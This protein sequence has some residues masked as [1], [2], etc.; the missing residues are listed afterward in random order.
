MSDSRSVEQLAALIRIGRA[1]SSTLELNEVLD[2]ILSE[3]LS[4]FDAEA[5]SVMLLRNGALRIRRA[6]GLSD[7]IVASTVVPLGQGIAGNVALT[8][9]MAFLNGKVDSSSEPRFT[10]VVD[11][12][13]AI[14][15]SLC[16]PLRARNGVEGVVMIRR[17]GTV[18]FTQD[19]ADFFC[20]VADQAAM[21][22]EN[23]RLFT[24]EQERARQVRVEQQKLEAIFKSMADGVVVI[25]DSGCVTL[26]NEP[27]VSMLGAGKSWL[28]ENL[29]DAFPVLPLEHI[30]ASLL[31]GDGKYEMDLNIPQAEGCSV[32]RLSA[33]CWQRASG[34]IEGLVFLLHDVTERVQVER[35]KTEF[36][37]A[38][39]HELKT[40]LTTIS[41]FVELLLDREFDRGKETQYLGICLDEAHRLQKLIDDLL[42]LAKLE[43]GRFE[44]FRQSACLDDVITKIV[45][46]F[47]ERYPKYGFAYCGGDGPVVID[48]DEMLVTQVL[49]NLL[50]NAVKYSPNGGKISV[51]VVRS[52]DHV[53]VSV[54][55]E[56]IGITRDKIPYVFDKFYRVDNSL[57]RKTG[58]T[59][60]GLAN[61][62]YI[63]EGHGGSIWVESEEGK[64]SKFTFV[65]PLKRQHEEYCEA[66]G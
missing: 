33:T 29:A 16:A 8:G 47:S 58:G 10:G 61:A 46:S 42:T 45:A 2:R 12:R 36:V 19:Q 14:C 63:V 22:V 49:V 55:D 51:A 62:R 3:L 1:V 31:S 21:A 32:L 25:D 24:S 53:S 11:R 5:G 15:S 27:G 4:L 59:G 44:F 65:L 41:G 6:I 17:G 30:K 26:I 23:A 66:I 52:D 37:S 40:P 38:V 20:S 35:M 34:G 13:D 7:E 9:E 18:P 64:G 56:G 43:S 57:T 50:S 39:S 28:G 60:L 54:S 48:I